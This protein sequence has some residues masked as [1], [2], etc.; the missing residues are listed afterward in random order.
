MNNFW[1]FESESTNRRKQAD[2]WSR[3]TRAS[4]FETLNKPGVTFNDQG[5]YQFSQSDLDSVVPQQQ[6]DKKA[7]AKKDSGGKNILGILDDVTSTVFGG[8]IRQPWDLLRPVQRALEAENKYVARPLAKAALSPFGDY[9]DLPGIVQMSA[10]AVF[11]PLSYIGPGAV[12]KLFK[13][14]KLA[15]PGLKMAAPML[16]ALTEGGS[17][18][19]L[20]H[21]A[22]DAGFN[23]AGAIGAGAI[24]SVGLPPILGAVAGSTLFGEGLKGAQEARRTSSASRQWMIEPELD[25]PKQTA[26]GLNTRFNVSEDPN[27]FSYTSPHG[28]NIDVHKSSYY[29]GDNYEISMKAQQVPSLREGATPAEFNDW[30]DQYSSQEPM[31]WTGRNSKGADVR[32]MLDIR[33]VL[34]DLVHHNPDA[35]FLALP[36]DQRRREVYERAGFRDIEK[37]GTNSTGTNGERWGYMK[38]DKQEFLKFIRGTLPKQTQRGLSIVGD[39]GEQSLEDL[40]NLSYQMMKDSPTGAKA[41]FKSNLEDE[42]GR[43]DQ[44]VKSSNSVYE[45][46]GRETKKLKDRAGNLVRRM[47]GGASDPA[48]MV[49][50]WDTMNDS[51]IQ[52]LYGLKL[53]SEVLQNA[54][55]RR[56]MTQSFRKRSA[57]FL[58]DT[59]IDTKVQGILDKAGVRLQDTDITHL[60]NYVQD[61]AATGP[62]FGA[63]VNDQMRT[64]LERANNANVLNVEEVPHMGTIASVVQNPALKEEAQRIAAMLPDSG[65]MDDGVLHLSD[66]MEYADKFE[67]LTPPQLAV[68]H[69]L[70]ATMAPFRGLEE[71][72][73]IKRAVKDDPTGFDVYREL[74]KRVEDVGGRRVETAGGPVVRQRL[75]A[76][77][78]YQQL[79]P[80]PSMSAGF[81]AGNQYLPFYESQSARIAQGY[82]AISNKW[83]DMALKDYSKS[84]DDLLPP[85]LADKIALHRTTRDQA[86]DLN[87]RLLTAKESHGGSQFKQPQWVPKNPELQNLLNDTNIALQQATPKARREALALLRTKTTLLIEATNNDLKGAQG[88]RKLFEAKIKGNRDPTARQGYSAEF[89]GRYYPPEMGSELQ[90]LNKVDA[91]SGLWKNI[92]DINDAVRPVMATLDLSFAA[93]QGLMAALSH[94]TNYFNAMK[95]VFSNG[96]G[97]YEMSLK[98]SGKLYQM[99]KDGVNWSARHDMAEFT[100]PSTIRRIPGVGKVAD[101][102]NRQFAMF[103]NVLR[104]NMYDMGLREGISEVARKQLA[105]NVNLITGFHPDSPGTTQKTLLFAPRFFRSQL[106][107][108]AD[109]LT[110]GDMSNTGASRSAMTAMTTGTLLTMG[111]N[112]MAGEKTITDPRDPNF[113]RVRWGGKD[114]SVFGTWDSLLRAF[115]IGMDQGP[116]EAAAYLARTKASPVVSRM[117]DVMQGETL[118]GDSVNFSSPSEV[119]KSMGTFSKGVLPLSVQQVMQDK[120]DI[121]DPQQII[122]SGLQFLGTKSSPLTP[123]EKMEIRREGLSKQDFGTDW[124]KLE[125]WQRKQLVTQYD[126]NVP[127]KGEIAKSFDFHHAI[128]ENYNEQQLKIDQTLPPGKDW[129]DAYHN[130]TRERVGAFAQWAQQNPEAAAKIRHGKPANANEAARQDFYNIFDTAD[131]EN[132][133]PDELSTKIE[134]FQANLSPDTAAYIERNTGLNNTPRV[135]EYKAAQKVLDPYWSIADKVWDKLSPKLP[136]SEQTH[137]LEAWQQAFVQKQQAQGVPDQV[138]IRRMQQNPVISEINRGVRTLRERLRRQSPAIDAE[139][140]K[141]YGAVPI[142][143]Q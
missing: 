131:K 24:D 115:T 79:E 44:T 33:D 95:T 71:A 111:L 86:H 25:A 81:K 82:K 16:E 74:T 48:D 67:N 105:R 39:S 97:D 31:D 19:V 121:T 2:A 10:E 4:A 104:S 118:G 91:A 137:S 42:A 98:N 129:T 133:T 117:L 59:G 49:A 109:A 64:I 11:D 85:D 136:D 122:G 70:D 36:T 112:D 13:A 46:M 116:T 84:L 1:E 15:G 41:A 5:Q 51:G 134:D 100:Y 75:G 94:P 119:L 45:Q 66:L 128:S 93:V 77:Q 27:G 62:R 56:T 7:E 114:W 90:Q 32:R 26:S 142:R 76:Q 106:G 135:K 35:E 6:V 125:P 28:N 141:W 37:P 107:F 102:T 17:R 92:N 12:T 52:D 8:E 127:N 96:Y 123:F 120:P 40:L 88:E 124:D 73:G 126:L 68:L 65:L 23:L 83:L 20:A 63:A 55:D 132:W 57:Q 139:L 108:V 22:K 69:S 34:G 138:I 110:K 60:I 38:L 89:H 143:S 47:S 99:I 87:R 18:N 50:L 53:P 103:G 61:R 3:Q 43:I 130:L 21:I 80:V 58:K 140:V 78:S 9:E 30:L 113:M 14:A 54:S 101:L 29:G 72:M